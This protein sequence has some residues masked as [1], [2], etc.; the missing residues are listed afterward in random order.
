M[1]AARPDVLVIGAGAV[2]VCA[3]WSLAERGVQV[4][5]IERSQRLGEDTAAGSGG[6][7]T[8]SHCIPLAGTRVLREL[9]RQLLGR[10]GMVSVRLRLD[11][12]LVRFAVHAV[13]HGGEQHLLSGLRALRDQ[14]RASRMRFAALAAAGIDIGLRHS[15]VM[16]V[17]NTEA[18]FARLRHEAEVLAAQGF[19]PRVLEGAAAAAVEPELREDLAGAVLWAEDDQCI[20]ARLTP[21]LA[22]ACRDRGVHFKLGTTVTGL[23]VGAATRVATTSGTFV[24]DHVV[25]AAGAETP[26]LGRLLGVRVPI[27][28]GKG[29]HVHLHDWPAP[30]QVPMILHE[31]VLGVTSMGPDLRVVGGVDFAGVGRS[32]DPRRIAGI[33]TRVGR[34]LRR[35]PTPG[36]HHAPT[37]SGLRPC[38]PDGLP[39]IGR[40]RRTPGI[41]VAAGHGMLGLT[42]AP[43]TGDDVARLVLC[44]PDAHAAAPWLSTF[45]PA[46]FGL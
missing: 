2:G 25:L 36:A 18:G 43:A 39:I 38:T 33:Y 35:P 46:R 14:S 44:D 30:V 4:T 45:T 8:P 1:S 9:P 42:L 23:G 11:P 10:D 13:R 12:Q 28:A 15:G 34:Y 19:E 3:A 31:D 5:V 6:L 16:N 17:C 24:A 20:P 40:L 41:V 22:D 37:W 7:I 21:A 27:E 26:A 29:H 32:V